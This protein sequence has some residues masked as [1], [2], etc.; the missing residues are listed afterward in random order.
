MR[1]LDWINLFELMNNR[2]NYFNLNKW[3][4]NEFEI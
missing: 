1:F 3:K 2:K 4:L